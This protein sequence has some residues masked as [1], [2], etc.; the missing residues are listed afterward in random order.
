MP[1]VRERFTS[2]HD[3]ATADLFE[4]YGERLKKAVRLEVTTAETG[5]FVNDGHAKFTFAPLPAAA[6]IAPVMGTTATHLDSDGRPDLVL[7]QKFFQNQRETGR[8]SGGLSLVLLRD[9][10]NSFLAIT[11][12]RSGIALQGDAR[13]LASTDLNN[14][15]RPDLIF[16]HNSAKPR[17]FLNSS[18]GKFIQVSLTGSHKNSKAIGARLIF[19]HAN[20]AH[21][22]RDLTAGGGYLTQQPSKF[23][24]T[25]PP[26]NPLKKITVIW[27]DGTQSMALIPPG[28][29][30]FNLRKP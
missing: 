17:F 12:S 6:Q 11:P 10:N 28:A 5:I 14:D 4:I 21:D 13:A 23:F 7:S 25:S 27:P 1:S 8:M 30:S 29:T 15:R 9:E 20:G 19:E 26:N 3:F 22:A 24:H 2:Y 16:A 18:L